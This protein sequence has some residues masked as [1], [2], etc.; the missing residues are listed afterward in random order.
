MQCLEQSPRPKSFCLD[1]SPSPLNA[2]SNLPS[3]G[4][5]NGWGVRHWG[6]A[7]DNVASFEVVLPQSPP[8]ATAP[9]GNGGRA[10]SG[11]GSGSQQAANGSAATSPK[12]SSSGGGAAVGAS[13]VVVDAESDKELFWGLRGGGAF[14]A[15]VT[16]FTLRLH[17][18]PAAL[19]CI[20]AVFPVAATAEVVAGF[21]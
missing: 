11:S 5:G 13:I 15:V 4:G 18:C 10:G 20:D 8:A 16:G 14:L 19:P 7:A 1:L 6:A 12:T 9:N 2:K 3:P 17:P 21:R